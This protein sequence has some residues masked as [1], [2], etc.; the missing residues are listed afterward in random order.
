MTGEE[1]REL[2]RRVDMDIG[3][4]VTELIFDM[5]KKSEY[6]DEIMEVMSQENWEIPASADGWNDRTDEWNEDDFDCSAMEYCSNHD[7]DPD[8]VDALEHW[9]VSRHLYEKL[10]AAGEMVIEWKGLLIWGRTNSGQAIILDTVIQRIYEK[11]LIMTDF[12]NHIGEEVINIQSQETGIIVNSA[13]CGYDIYVEYENGT[14]GHYFRY[15][16]CGKGVERIKL[17]QPTTLTPI[18]MTDFRNHIGEEVINVCLQETGII[19]NPSDGHYYDIRVDYEDGTCG[20]YFRDGTCDKG[21]KNIKLKHPT[22]TTL[23]MTDFR[24]HI[25][26]E[27]IRFE[28]NRVGRINLG[29]TKYEISVRW[30]DTDGETEYFFNG[31]YSKNDTKPRIKLKQPTTTTTKETPMIKALKSTFNSNINN[32]RSTTLPLTGGD[33]ALSNAKKAIKTALPEKYHYLIDLPGA[34][35]IIA[36]ATVL[37]INSFFPDHTNAKKLIDPLLSASQVTLVNTFNPTEILATLLGDATNSNDS[38][39]EDN[40]TTTPS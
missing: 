29:N 1:E 31:T 19:V 20:H 3:A 39:N 2:Q 28:D 11:G 24:D 32:F 7:L 27:V 37:F 16:T 40:E 5:V 18:I 22:P 8:Q 9:L 10:E 26:K 35:L 38:N 12:F 33:I 25:G 4:N 34:D 14:E 13:D 36:N 17:K 21:V 23:I 6:C 15:G 30:H